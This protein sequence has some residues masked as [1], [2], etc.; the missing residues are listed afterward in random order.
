MYPADL[1]GCGF[2]RTIWA[3]EALAAQGAPVRVI[4]PDA[5]DEEQIQAMWVRHDDARLDRFVDVRRPDCDVV[6]LQRPLTDTL[7]RAIPILQDKGVRVV[8]EVDDDFESISP[9]NVSWRAVQP[10]LSPRRNKA[11]LRAACAQADLVVCSTPALA[12]RY[13]GH[14]RVR[15]VRNRV[16][17]WYLGVWGG[18]RERVHVGWSGSIETHPGDLQVTRGAVGRVVRATGAQFA[19]IGTGKGVRQRLGLPDAPLACG[20]V[21]IDLYPE[22]VAQLDVGIV[23]LE[24]SAFNEAKSALKMMEMAALGVAVVASPTAENTR[25]AQLLGVVLAD[26]PK[27]WEGTLRRLITDTAW[28][29]DRIGAA[30]AAMRGHTIEGNLGEWWDAWAAPVNTP[31]APS[32]A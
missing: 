32:A 17:S 13:G 31:C 19:V 2:Y 8:V 28:R 11:W 14:G 21:P 16:P 23:P 6:V 27:V 25:M 1:G 15:V 26:R 30:R 5:P 22:A 9:A 18:E 24:P 7:A 3:G 4:R 10:H 12:R 29:E 20:W